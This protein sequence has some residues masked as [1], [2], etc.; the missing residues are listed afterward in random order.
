MP[1]MWKLIGVLKLYDLK[2]LRTSACGVARKPKL[3]QTL[4]VLISSCKADD[5]DATSGDIPRSIIS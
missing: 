3:L 4:S 2:L 5:I 1:R